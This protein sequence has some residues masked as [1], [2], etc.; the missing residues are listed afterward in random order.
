VQIQSDFDFT[1]EIIYIDKNVELEEKYGEQVP[2]IM[3]DGEIHDFFK[4][5]EA[6]FRKALT[7]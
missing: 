2:V 7:S 1:I 5:N 4:L 6:R 3:I